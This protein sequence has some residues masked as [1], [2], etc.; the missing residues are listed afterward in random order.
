MISGASSE[1]TE[2]VQVLFAR[3]DRCLKEVRELQRRNRVIL[4][5]WRARGILPPEEPRRRF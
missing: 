1:K 5:G 2:D 4:D 3:V